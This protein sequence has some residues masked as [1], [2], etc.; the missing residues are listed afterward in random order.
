MELFK[1]LGTIAITNAEANDALDET[2]EKAH[3]TSNKFLDGIATVGK[4]ATAITIAATAAVTALTGV[5][6]SAASVADNVDKMSQKIGISR[7]AYQELEFI[8]SQSGT[9]VDLL[10]M[11]MKTLVNQMQSAAE[12]TESAVSTFEKLGVSIYDSSG[13]LKDQETMLWETISA[14]QAMDNQTEK[15]AIANDLLGRSAS[16]MMPMLNGAEGSIEA[17]RQQAHDLGLVLDDEA[18]DAG[19][20]LT[21]TI[22]QVKRSFSAIFTKLGVE[23]MPLFQSMCD[24]IISH[25]PEIQSTFERLVPVVESF[26]VEAIPKMEESLPKLLDAFLELAPSLVPLIETLPMLIDLFVFLIPLVAE[27]L[28]SAVGILSDT[29]GKLADF[30]QIYVVPAIETFVEWIGPILSDIFSNAEIVLQ[31]FLD[32]F[33]GVMGSLVALVEYWLAIFTGDWE[34]VWESTKTF[35]VGIWDAIVGMLKMLVPD[36]IRII[37]ENWDKISGFFSN[38]WTWCK[39]AFT[40]AKNWVSNIFTSIGTAISSKI[41]NAIQTVKNGIDKIKSFFNF[42]WSLPKLKMPH[43]KINGSFSLNPP[44]VPSFGVDW[45]AKAMDEPIIMNSPTAFGINKLGQVM[46]G[47][48]AGSEVVSGTDTLMNMISEAVAAKN[49]GLEAILANI[50]AFLMEYMPQM[51]NMQ[52]VMDSGAVVGQLAPGMDAALG[53]LAVRNGRGV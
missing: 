22:D 41:Q 10:Q 27:L 19:V 28:P 3:E 12:G 30:V 21:D 2:K 20:R 9:Q 51:A 32:V 4:W 14:L 8:C 29:F 49:A 35:F 34:G 47:G 18:I 45:Y 53:K 46:A 25:M 39:N 52:L 48:E 36:L 26:V 31:G 38:A 42:Q 50:L 24:M 17:M 23:F 37:T 15:A 7:E 43:F 11:G 16:E 33:N 44:S 5:V 6:T 1:I 13:A 40:T